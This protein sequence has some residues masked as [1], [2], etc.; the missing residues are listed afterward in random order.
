MSGFGAIGQF[1]ITGTWAST[2]AKD[3]LAVIGGTLGG[4]W[5]STGAK[6]TFAAAGVPSAANDVW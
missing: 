1:P 4:T 2:E 6:D 3:T 5:A